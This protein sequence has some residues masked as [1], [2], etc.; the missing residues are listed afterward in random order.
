MLTAAIYARKSTE[1]TGVA[2]ESR[3]VSRQVEHAHA[4]ATR[5]GWIVAGEHVYTDDGIS[6]AEFANRPGFVRLM[7]ALK[8]RAPFDALIVSELSRLG[9]EQLETGYALKQLS[10]AGVKIFSYLEDREILLD[11]PTDKFLMSAVSFAAEIEREKARQRTYDALQRKAANGYVTGGRVFGYDNV[12]TPSGVRR[13]INQAEAAVVQRIFQ[14]AADGHG[15]TAIAKTLNHEG[16]RP[17]R[18]QQAR[19]AGWADNSVR[20]VLLRPLYRGESV[21]N[22]TRKR[23]G[24]GVKRGS[25]RPASEHLHVEAPEWRIVTDELWRRAHVQLELNRQRYNFSPGQP[26]RRS[27]A[28]YLLTGL[29]QCDVCGGSFEVR[30]RSHGRRRVPFYGCQVHSHRG[31][32][33][34]ANRLA[35]PMEHANDRVLTELK[36]SLLDREI[37][38]AA[39]NQAVERLSRTHNDSGEG[40][41]QS[42]LSRLDV[43]LGRLTAAVAGGAEP[44]SL[45]AAIR[46]RETRKID[47][48]QELER[49][50]RVRRPAVT[51]TKRIVSDLQA[52]VAEEWRELLSARG[53]SANR[54]LRQVIAGRLIMEPHVE[55]DA[56]P[57]YT[58]RGTGTLWPVISGVIPQNLASPTRLNRLYFEGP[59]AA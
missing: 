59:L 39:I 58:F 32:A 36:R 27:G 8:P 46:E 16:A 47:L 11:T 38:E 34:C 4:F 6:G 25:D 54:V 33:I 55:G 45:V 19:P 5:E 29:L 10:Q 43:E 23:D 49:R 9:R 21:W 56:A 37:L 51:D 18:P 24:W 53:P 41:L 7:N 30:S 44:S 3:S 26:G 1:Q 31:T 28:K 42:E 35:V 40:S 17:P 14:L 22:Q 15:H 20:E 12:R 13:S 2:E 52:R 50:R 48:V 57:F